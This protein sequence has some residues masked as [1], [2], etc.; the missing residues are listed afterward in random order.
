MTLL[1]F[2]WDADSSVGVSILLEAM[3]K[4]SFMVA[5]HRNAAS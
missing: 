4:A 5:F 1:Y 2:A 3:Q